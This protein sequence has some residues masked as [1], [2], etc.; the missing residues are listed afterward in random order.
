MLQSKIKSIFTDKIF[1]DF[2]R[3]SILSVFATF[4]IG[5]ASYLVRRIM[6]DSLS[7][8]D[9]A[10]FY[11]IFAF[12]SLL[13]IL[14]R[15]GTAEVLL[16]IIPDLRNRMNE[17]VDRKM[18][19]TICN[20]NF[21]IFFILIIILGCITPWLQR[22]YFPIIAT[23]YLYAFLPFLMLSSLESIVTNMF[24]ALKAFGYM[25]GVQV[26]K[27]IMI[28]TGLFLILNK[29]QLLGAIAVFNISI[30]LMLLISF[31]I[32]KEKFSYGLSR[33][34]DFSTARLIFK[35]CSW[36]FLLSLGGMALNELGT[37]FLVIFNSTTEVA[38]F[39]IA[40]PI[41]MIIKSLY[42][43]PLVFIPFV[44]DMQSK[45]EGKKIKKY[46]NTIAF[47]VLAIGILMIPFFL[48]WG[49]VTVSLLF[50]EKFV[51]AK[52]SV[53]FLSEAMIVSI[54]AQFNI[55]TLN[56]IRCEHVSAIITSAVTVVAIL[57]YLTLS[58]P[59]GAAGTAVGA[60]IAGTIWS[61]AS[62]IA[63]RC[64]LQSS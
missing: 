46:I 16:F 51:S 54:I 13:V 12:F 21:I 52:W 4:I 53:F 57:L 28:L 2:F 30:F 64:R 62:Y 9:Y 27:T 40:V 6:A 3:G 59:Y 45:G 18:F 41:A 55:N 56:S 49:E 63:L 19:S 10:A 7:L 32:L 36:L 20:F 42:C 26:F 11:G 24:N 17:N 8:D 14:F 33:K 22:T 31:V 25:N 34:M 39:N 15:F 37:I 23:W 38:L 50:G 44:A 58:G 61:F 1:Q 29:F 5:V 60:L 43:I 35:P 48:L 47:F